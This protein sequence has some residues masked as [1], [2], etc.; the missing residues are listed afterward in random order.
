MMV[1]NGRGKLSVIFFLNIFWEKML[2]KIHFLPEK[3]AKI[4]LSHYTSVYRA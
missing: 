1:D 3:I 2:I 4:K